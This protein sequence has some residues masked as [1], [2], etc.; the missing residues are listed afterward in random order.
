MAGPEA[1]ELGCEGASRDPQTLER[2]LIR[3]G[4]LDG[5]DR[6]FIMRRGGVWEELQETWTWPVEL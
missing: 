4:S 5:I 3:D 6:E 2:E 1:L